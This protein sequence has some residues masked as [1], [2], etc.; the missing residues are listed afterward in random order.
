MKKIKLLIV[1]AIMTLAMGM[2]TGCGCSTDAN[3]ANDTTNGTDEN[4]T[5]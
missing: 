5:D 3:D 2:A 1:C 4:G